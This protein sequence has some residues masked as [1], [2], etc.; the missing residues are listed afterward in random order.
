[1]TKGKMIKALK[2]KGIRRTAEGKK[3]ELVK[4]YEVTKLYYDAFGGFNN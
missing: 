3:L 4:A 2:E 1:M